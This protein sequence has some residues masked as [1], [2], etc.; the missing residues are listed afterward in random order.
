[1]SV[2]VRRVLLAWVVLLALLGSLIGLSLLRLGR[3]G[4]LLVLLLALA[5]AACIALAFMRLRDTQPLGRGY[6][7]AAAV[8]LLIM[9]GLAS[10]DRLTREDVPVAVERYP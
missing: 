2:A 9:F 4:P 5:M 8:W 7:L 6:A 3:F 10:A 1:M